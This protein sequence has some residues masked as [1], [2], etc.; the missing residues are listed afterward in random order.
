MHAMGVCPCRSVL[1][2]DRRANKTVNHVTL[3]SRLA[4]NVL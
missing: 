3:H 4:C 1:A 2:R